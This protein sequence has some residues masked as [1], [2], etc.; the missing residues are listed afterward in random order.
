MKV[1]ALTSQMEKNLS[2][3]ESFPMTLSLCK[4]RQWSE[5]RPNLLA[6]SSPNTFFFPLSFHPF[7]RLTFSI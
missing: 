7:L 4:G 6:G 1:M 5:Y 2:W 3:I